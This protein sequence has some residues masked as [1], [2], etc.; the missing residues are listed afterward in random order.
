MTELKL[1][2]VLTGLTGAA[3]LVQRLLRGARRWR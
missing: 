3:W 2:V 1:A